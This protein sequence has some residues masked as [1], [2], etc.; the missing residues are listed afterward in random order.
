MSSRMATIGALTL[1]LG[2]LT[3]APAEAATTYDYTVQN[4]YQSVDWS[5][6][7][8]KAGLH[9]H[10]TESDGRNTVHEMITQAYELGFNIFPLTDHNVVNETWVLPKA[11]KL[12]E[13]DKP[14]YYPTKEQA[15]AFNAGA[16][17]D[18]APGMIEVPGSAEQ[19]LG[20]HVNTFFTETNLLASDL[21]HKISIIDAE[22]SNPKPLQH[23]NHPGRYYGGKNK[24]VVDGVDKGKEAATNPRNVKR[25]VDIFQS[26]FSSLVGMEII[27]KKD[28]DSYSDRILWDQIL[29]QTMPER[30][31]WGFSNDDAH[32]TD[33]L[34]YS[35]NQFLLPSLDL[36]SFH[37]AMQSGAF[38]STAL[39]AKRELGAD[40][41]GDRTVPGP[42]I[43]NIAVDQAA[44]TITITSPN[45]TKV[46]W[47]A[48][49]EVIA[50][51]NTLQLD[52]VNNKVNNYVRAQVYNQNGI[53]FTNPFGLTRVADAV[54]PTD[55]DQGNTTNPDQGNTTGPDQG[56]TTDPDQGNT[57]NPTKPDQNVTPNKPDT[58]ANAEV[59]NSNTST[60]GNAN[61]SS[62]VVPLADTGAAPLALGAIAIVAVGAGVALRKPTK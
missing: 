28:G 50:T 26:G 13:R 39:V 7:Q 59:K 44:D 29:M 62:A 41:R 57:T 5:W 4:P 46:E 31:V 24:E 51:G 20:N 17:R 36:E 6:T 27:N 12:S 30:P 10:T 18:G 14:N 2:L 47:V 8:Y 58:G 48:D 32:S 19:S 38:Y 54:P 61:S 37:S 40:F 33:A 21:K 23:I 3:A 55:P 22:T 9:N 42:V 11:K 60:G 1:A 52:N 56:N 49:G 16:G 34:G 53:S 43:S 35:Y 15:D 45:A 25:Y